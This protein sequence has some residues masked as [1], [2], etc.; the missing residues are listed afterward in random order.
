LKLAFWLALAAGPLAVLLWMAGGWWPPVVEALYSR[1]LYPWVMAPV[2]RALA[3]LPFAVAPVLLVAG[4][5]AAVGALFLHPRGWMGVLAG[6]SVLV[7]WFILGW[8][9][10]Y[11][12][13]SWAANVGWT[14]RGGTVAELDALARDL[15]ARVGPLRAQAWKDGPP[16]WLKLIRAIPAA[17]DHAAL[18]W[19]LL[20]GQ[21]AAPKAS[22]A[23]ESMSWLGISG[24]YMPFTGEPLV[25]TGPG[26]WSLP[27]TAAH[28][29][30]HLHGWAREDEA[31][32][33]AFLVLRDC[34]DPRLE[35]S[36][37]SMAL[38]YVAEAL[39]SAAPDGAARWKAIAATLP[40]DVLEDWRSYFR[41]WD[42]FKGP[43]QQAAQSVNDAYLKVQG[44][45]DGVKS[46]G[47]M[48]DLLLAAEAVWGSTSGP[49]E[50]TPAPS[51]PA[52][53]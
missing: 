10:N 50:S 53:R 43:V 47:R 38:L 34:G 4:V 1:G 49:G 29:S 45:A 7:A 44:Q 25:N 6:L 5:L 14:V 39:G 21:F 42:R 23:P 17:Y 51:K 18:R 8:G 33:L 31:N 36:A 27:F 11:Q 24:I 37:W 12:R 22:P 2:S 9:L 40:H 16:P 3:A 32:F 46:Y 26:Q 28:E 41:Y 20:A 30:A 19:P 48:V 52:P 35:Y 15:A 13:E